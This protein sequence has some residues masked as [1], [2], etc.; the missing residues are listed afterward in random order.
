MRAIVIAAVIA[1]GSSAALAGP[2]DHQ[3][4]RIADPSRGERAEHRTR[5]APYALTGD[6]VQRR[7][8]KFRDVPQG[9]G[10]SERLPFWTWVSE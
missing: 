7:V 6:R 10:Q 4:R 3:S 5:R 2:S 1:L 9:R 8:I